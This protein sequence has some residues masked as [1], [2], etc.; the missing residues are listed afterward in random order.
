[1][2]GTT[3]VVEVGGGAAI[4]GATVGARDAV[5]GGDAAG[6]LD[7]AG[8]CVAGAE[9]DGGGCVGD[10]IG[11]SVPD[12]LDGAGAEVAVSATG[13]APQLAP[14]NSRAQP[15]AASLPIPEG[16]STSLFERQ[17]PLHDVVDL[18]VGEA[19][20]RHE[21]PGLHRGRVLDPLREVRLVDR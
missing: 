12:G 9:V 14:T 5:A 19:E 20:I 21:R 15:A 10:T 4:V 1:M 3:C 8:A 11:A 6:G 2:T 13:G 7:D 16:E 18:I 17:Q